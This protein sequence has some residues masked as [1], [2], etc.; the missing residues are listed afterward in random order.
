[1]KTKNVVAFLLLN[2]LSYMIMIYSYL[3]FHLRGVCR[4]IS[5]QGIA[6]NGSQG[7]IYGCNTKEENAMVYSY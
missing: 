6:D 1:M 3:S 2:L 4:L 5:R 7:R